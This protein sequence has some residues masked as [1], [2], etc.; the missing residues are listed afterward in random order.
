MTMAK[1]VPKL[2]TLAIV[3]DELGVKPY[4]VEYVLRTR[5]HIQPVAR[6]GIIRLFD[7]E[8]VAAIRHAL[9]AIAARKASGQS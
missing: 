5:P 1:S 4:Q 2:R 9:T 3:A 8:A 6:A 7:R